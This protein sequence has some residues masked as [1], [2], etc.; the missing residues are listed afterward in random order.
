[1]GSSIGQRE[2]L[3]ASEKLSDKTDLTVFTCC[4]FP[5]VIDKE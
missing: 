4:S 2:N 5:N 1:M 3:Q